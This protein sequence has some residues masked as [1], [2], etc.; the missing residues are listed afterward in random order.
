MQCPKCNAKMINMS[1]L[2]IPSQ[3]TRGEGITSAEI[4]GWSCR[5]GKWIES[6]F[7]PVMTRKVP[8]ISYT[9][10]PGGC[11][12]RRTDIQGQ[13]VKQGVVKHMIEIIRLR[14]RGLGWYSIKSILK[15]TGSQNIICKYF[16][17][18]NGGDVKPRGE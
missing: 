17:L 2:G 15:L 18:E 12:N 8:K 4:S 11:V 5:C 14:E 7:I 9:K 6:V 10:P 13:L 1:G 16:L 3:L